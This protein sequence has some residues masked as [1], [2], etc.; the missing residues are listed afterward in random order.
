MNTIFD[1]GKHKIET[2][3]R[4]PTDSEAAT[5]WRDGELAATDWLVPTTDHPQHSAYIAYRQALR[6]WPDSVNFPHMKPTL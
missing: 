1:S 3:G 5:A 2:S 4:L 6:D